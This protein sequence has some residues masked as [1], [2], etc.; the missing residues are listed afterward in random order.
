MEKTEKIVRY[1]LKES[2]KIGIKEKIIVL[3]I[4]ACS[5]LFGLY[6]PI[7]LYRIDSRNK[8]YSYLTS[9][10]P[11]SNPTSIPL[12]ATLALTTDISDIKTNST[13]SATISINSP[14]Q[15]IEAADFLLHFDPNYLKVA[16]LSTGKFFSLYPIKQT[17]EDFVKISGIAGLVN[18]RFLIPKGE[19]VVATIIF[20]TL[21][22]TNSTKII[23]DRKM[24][25]V[26]SEGV[27][28]LDVN[29]IVDLSLVIR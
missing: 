10:S 12:P 25:I 7:I 17:G 20:K 4:L 21:E 22:A 5:F 24:T 11:T 26:A 29:N 28:I 8:P 23:F 6:I 16:T 3:A 18:N 9:P 15:G 27:N 14:N 2:Q 13:F 19:G 1:Y